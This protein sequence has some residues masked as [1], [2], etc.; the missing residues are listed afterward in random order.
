MDKDGLALRHAPFRSGVKPGMTDLA[1]FYTDTAERM[2]R[3][4]EERTTDR[5][6]GVYQVPTENYLD[7]DRWQREMDR[8]FKRVPLMLAMT[9]ELRDVGDYKAMEVVGQPVLIT[10]GKDGKAR[11]FL[12]VCKHRANI[13]ASEGK[14]NCKAFSC[15]YHGWTYSSEGKLMGIAEAGN[16]GEVDKEPLHLTELPC[17]EIAGMIFVILTPGLP[18]DAREWLGGMYDH[19]AMLKLEDW[20]YHKSKVMTGA[21]WKLVWD[22]YIEGYHFQAAHPE[23]IAP[24]S[25]SNRATIDGFG[26]HILIGYPQVDI[27]KLRDVPRAEWPNHENN[28]YDVLRTLFPNLSMFLA[29]EMC[30]Y[31]QIFPGP[32]PDQNTTVMNYI[33]PKKPETAEAMQALDE[34]CDFFFTVV[35]T[36]DYHLTSRVQQGVKSGAVKQVTFG[37]CEPGPQFFHK[38]VDHL[39]DE[40]GQIPAPVM[41]E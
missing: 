41:R 37:R 33:F 9:A 26:P 34:M 11:A 23:T 5:A 18:I 14:G 8:I 15:P 16:F 2:L 25:P 32:D 17:E 40:T 24:R 19:F 39:L 28:G 12:N 7:P 29:P 38:W 1:T 22:G 10:R 20:Y 21:N 36:E 30:Q 6:S 31:A 13:L 3:H 27:A 35:Q 4:V